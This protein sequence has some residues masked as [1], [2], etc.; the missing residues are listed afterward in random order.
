MLSLSAPDSS[1]LARSTPFVRLLSEAAAE[2]G[3]SLEMDGEYGFVGRLVDKDGRG[4]PIF[5][6][7]LGLNSDAAAHLAADK[8]YTARWLAASGLPTPNGQL[9]FNSTY[10]VRMALRNA[11][12]AARLPGKSVA[13]SFGEKHGWPVILKP[14]TGSEGRDIR[15]CTDAVHL[16]VELDRAL[17]SDEILRIEPCIPGRDYRVL[18]LDGD[19][20]LAYE[21]I[22]L[23]VTGDGTTPLGDLI[24]AALATLRKRHRGSKIAADD[25]RVLRR[26]A[27]DGHDLGTILTA[28]KKQRLLDNAN[29]STGGAL[30]DLT[31]QLPPEA[32]ML[33]SRAAVSLGLRIA[34]V[35]I[36]APN[37][38][39]STNGATVLEVNSAPGLDYFATAAPQNWLR[40]RAIVTRML[41]ARL[42][43]GT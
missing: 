42:G 9:V 11:E 15:L 26:L 35:D 13:A 41:R 19:V 21:R 43:S 29:L 36:L 17:S 22:P 24:D 25:P 34:G 2:I 20:V 23:S 3:V 1:L 39:D 30:R 27:A 4:Y 14:N 10:C 5:G 16:A 6:K 18:V 28:G 8:E 33:A 37:L 38:E 31:G 12:T 40:A 7:S 32:E